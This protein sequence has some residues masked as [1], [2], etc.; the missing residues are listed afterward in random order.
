[1]LTGWLVAPQKLRTSVRAIL[2]LTAIAVLA[3]SAFVLDRKG[4]GKTWIVAACA[5]VCI[6]FSALLAT[7]LKAIPGA[8]RECAVERKPPQSEQL[9]SRSTATGA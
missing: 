2:W 3:V 1:M 9:K 5:V 8:I 6:P 4:V 7:L